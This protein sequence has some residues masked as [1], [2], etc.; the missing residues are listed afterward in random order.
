MVLTL[1][2]TELITMAL[3][4]IPWDVRE[5]H[6][7]RHMFRVLERESLRRDGLPCGTQEDLD[8]LQQWKSGL[9]GLGPGVVVDYVPE[10]PQGF[11]LVFAREGEDLIRMPKG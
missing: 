11:V 3:S 4:L 7:G 9:A 10:H 2:S 5:E 6:R 1:D 8:Q